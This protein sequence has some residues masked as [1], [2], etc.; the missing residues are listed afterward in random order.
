MLVEMHANILFSSLLGTAPE[1]QMF[2][3][4]RATW[5]SRTNV[6]TASRR[7]T[8]PPAASVD[9]QNKTRTFVKQFLSVNFQ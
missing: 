4:T 9:K 2:E 8:D 3:N 1:Q 7:K 5:T 6:A